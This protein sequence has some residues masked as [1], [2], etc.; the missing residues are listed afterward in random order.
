MVRE[1]GSWLP[2]PGGQGH[3]CYFFTVHYLGTILR[4]PQSLCTEPSVPGASANRTE[5]GKSLQKPF[6]SPASEL[7]AAFPAAP[8]VLWSPTTGKALDEREKSRAGW[9]A[10][11]Q[12]G[13]L[14]KSRPCL[15]L[16]FWAWLRS[17]HQGHLGC[18]DGLAPQT[19]GQPIFVSASLIPVAL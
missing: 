19:L 16:L 11:P 5:A 17:W 10:L 3:C 18:L 1:W 13:F 9:T 12:G 2:L 15:E 4:F 14:G 8:S 7:A 6:Q